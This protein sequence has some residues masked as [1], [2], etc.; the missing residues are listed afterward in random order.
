MLNN[1]LFIFKWVCSLWRTFRR[2]REGLRHK[3][4]H[5]LKS[6]KGWVHLDEAHLDVFRSLMTFRSGLEDSENQ[7][8]VAIVQP[9][10][11]VWAF[12]IPVWHIYSLGRFPW[13][14]ALLCTSGPSQDISMEMLEKQNVEEVKASNSMGSGLC[15]LVPDTSL[16]TV[17]GLISY[18][19]QCFRTGRG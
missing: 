19:Y 17:Y 18:C 13:S 12:L 10:F 6:R 2:C 8:P 15:I 11:L 4:N 1:F 16:L 3:S 14:T 9:S 7:M 5:S